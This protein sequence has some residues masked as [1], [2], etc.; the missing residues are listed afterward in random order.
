[1]VYRAASS[2]KMYKWNMGTIT[3]KLVID[4]LYDIDVKAY[5]YR[6]GY[7]S[8]DDKLNDKY[9]LGFIAEELDEVFPAAVEYDEEGKPEKWNINILFPALFQ[10]VKEQHEEIRQLK[11][12]LGGKHG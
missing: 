3:T 2:S 5:K 1:M 6:K 4:K 7:L 9:T 8:E 11:E 12:M 10:L